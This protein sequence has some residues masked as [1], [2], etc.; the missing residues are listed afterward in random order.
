MA[1]NHLLETKMRYQSFEN[2]AGKT[3]SNRRWN[4]F[5]LIIGFIIGHW[6]GQTYCHGPKCFETLESVVKS[7]QARHGNSQNGDQNSDKIQV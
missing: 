1:M 6:I 4:L 5:K 7:P 2:L 3:S